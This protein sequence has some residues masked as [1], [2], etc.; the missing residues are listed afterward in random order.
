MRLAAVA[1]CAAA[2]AAALA[3]CG[4]AASSASSGPVTPSAVKAPAAAAPFPVTIK[5]AN[6]TVTI[7]SK[8]ARI[9]SLSPTSTEDLYAVGAGKQV[10]AVDADS[11]YPPGV[12]RTSLS[13]L[14][15]NIEAIARYN[16]S[17]VVAWENTGG[18]V[19]GLAKLGIPVLLEPAVSTLAGAYA[20]IEQIGEATGHAAQAAQV[21]ASMKKQIAADVEKAG[22]SH[23]DLTYYWELSANPYYSA[24]S[25]TFIGQIAGLFGLKNIADAADKASDGGYPELSEEYIIAARPQIVFLADNQPSDGGQ[26]PA[27]VARRPGWSVI[28]AVK[29]H[30][31][32]ALNDDVASRWGPRLPQLVAQIA[33]A[34]EHAPGT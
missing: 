30:E 15:P 23:K 1:A 4:S 21:V 19:A 13:G 26:T 24:T 8:P 28:P 29:D 27:V 14:T 25:K 12:P 33:L 17:L 18:L 3:G 31:V 32:I 10:V 16:P 5:A 2:C 9:V 6:G 11:N 34:V 7:K 20:Q 22:A